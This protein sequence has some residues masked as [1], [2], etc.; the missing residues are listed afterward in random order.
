MAARALAAALETLYDP[1]VGIVGALDEFRTEPDAPRYLHYRARICDPAAL[2]GVS[3]ARAI[4]AAA[5]SREAAAVAALRASIARYCAALYDRQ[6]LPTAAAADA[7]LPCLKPADFALFSDEQYA[8]PGFPFVRFAEDTPVKWTSLID[9]VSGETV[10]A[11]AAMVW[12]PFSYLRTAGDL[13]ITASNPGGLACGEGVAGAALAGICDVVARDAAALFWQAVTQPPRVRIETLPERLR[14]MVRRFE[15]AGDAVIILDVTTDNR[16]PSFVAIAASDSPDRPAYVFAYAAG[17][18]PGTAVDEALCSLAEK[19][20][21]AGEVARSRPRPSATNQ[22]E[23]V[24]SLADHVNFATDHDNRHLFATAL[25]SDEQRDLLD[26]ESA[27]TGSV[28]GDLE[29]AIGRIMATG[30]RVS[31]ANLTSEDIAGLGLNVCRAVI[32]GYLPLFAGHRRRALGG[33]RLYD[34]PRKLGY[35]GVAAGSGGNP[36]PHP[37]G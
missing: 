31:V 16:I 15:R 8:W 11:P 20:R 23:D 2:G 1:R 7:G 6:G 28:D 27:A 33:T 29:A 26:V 13:P 35:R 22:W 37:F 10:Y 17:L 12:Y 18:D 9:L 30:Y 21:E 5:P 36:A 3:T 25:S 4:E 32:P 19:R 14:D 24:L 34:T